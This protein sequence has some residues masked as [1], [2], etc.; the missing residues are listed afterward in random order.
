MNLECD[1]MII[2]NMKITNSRGESITFGRHFKL[3]DDFETSGLSAN[4]IYSDTT[5]DGSSYQNTT[6]ENKDFNVVFFIDRGSRDDAWIEEQRGLAIRVFNPKMNPFRVDVTTN[7]GKELYIMANLE[8]TPLFGKGFEQDNKLWLKGLLEFTS[9]DPHFYQKNEV[10]V[11]LASWIGG[12]KFPLSIPVGGIAMGRRSKTLIRN[13]K[14]TG[15]V[16]TGMLIRFRARTTITNPSLINVNTYE[17]LKL[18]VEMT[19]G[20]VI[21]VSTHKR[22]KTITLIRNNIRTDAFNTMD[23]V[24]GSRFLQLEPGDNMFRYDV[25][26]GSLDD[27]EVSIIFANK[28]LGV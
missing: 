27:L 16:A 3:I 14:N 26:S 20:D 9:G 12:F 10:R 24:S 18:N 23:V 6:L 17:V 2:K 8:S 25:D 11:E 28:Y 21:E 15:Q 5:D 7:G 1:R 19:G 4:V 22:R 13:V